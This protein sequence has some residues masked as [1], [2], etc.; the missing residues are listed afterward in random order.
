M[1]DRPLGS[2]EDFMQISLATRVNL[3]VVGN[4]ANGLI[5]SLPDDQ[6]GFVYSS[7]DA[8]SSSLDVFVSL[9]K[10]DADGQISINSEEKLISGGLAARPGFSGSQVPVEVFSGGN[11]SGVIF[12]AD[13]AFQRTQTEIF[14]LA[15]SFS[16]DGLLTSQ[17]PATQ[18]LGN[19]GT[20]SEVYFHAVKDQFGNIIFA[21]NGW[22]NEGFAEIIQPLTSSG[23]PIGAVLD[24]F[25]GRSFG[26]SHPIDVAFDGD[27]TL[28]V[29]MN[30]E[31]GSSTGVI[32][33]LGF[34][35]LGVPVGANPVLIPQFEEFEPNPPFFAPN[36]YT[37]DVQIESNGD[38]SF[39]LTQRRDGSRDLILASVG[40]VSDDGS[41]SYGAPTLVSVLSNGIGGISPTVD[42]SALLL[43]D[44][45]AIVTYEVGGNIF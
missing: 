25:P 10:I 38:G 40:S 1:P 16:S 11:G 24:P 42:H 2:N 4:Q 27:N 19:W 3:S 35:A 33:E 18:V 36:Y 31:V 6:I 26:G 20:S 34:D 22:L 9:G 17:N 39:L 14:S 30:R 13:V 41:I 15:Y 8:N 43:S 37:Q 45:R 29:G 44:G 12:F 7:P 32:R 21:Y 23:S 5:I 28:V